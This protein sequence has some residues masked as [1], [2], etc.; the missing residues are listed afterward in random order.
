MTKILLAF[1]IAFIV[2][3]GIGPLVIW[4]MKKQKAKQT[5]LHYVEAHA[6][7]QGTPTMGG[8]IFLIAIGVVCAIFLRGGSHLALMSLAVTFAYALLGFLDDFLKVKMKQNLGLKPYQKIIFQLAIAVLVAVFV[9]R[10][11]D[12][13]SR[14]E[15]PFARKS[16][17]F[18]VWIIPFT[19]VVFLACTNAVNLTDG[20]DGLA[21]LSTFIYLIIFVALILLGEF[22]SKVAINMGSNA[23]MYSLVIFA[24]ATC[25]ALLAFLC[26]NAYPAKIF[27]GDTGSM[28][29]GAVVACVAIFSRTTLFIP[30][31]GVVFVASA[32]S[33]C[34]Q[35]AYYKKTK[36]RVFLMAPLHHH[37]EKKGVHETKIVAMYGVVTLMV[38]I[39]TLLF[40]FI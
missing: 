33:V 32:L 19:V 23:E 13:G 26:F 7:K 24:V 11:P 9:Y 30:L 22:G 4:F 20:L 37:F 16:V 28:A 34:I 1:I 8:V 25:G 3:L 5:I 12:V 29:L 14:I 39:F 15:L 21:S 6:K 27:M 36:K 38:G 18:G 10:S 17:D 40:E 2:G 31:V 35:V